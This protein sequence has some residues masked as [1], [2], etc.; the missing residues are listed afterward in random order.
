MNTRA[1]APLRESTEANER[2]SMNE[3]NIELLSEKIKKEK[4]MDFLNHRFNEKL[5]AMKNNKHKN[6]NNANNIIDNFHDFEFENFKNEFKR[7]NIHYGFSPSKEKVLDEN[8]NT[9]GNLNYSKIIKENRKDQI[10]ISDEQLCEFK[11]KFLGKSEF[12]DK[13]NVKMF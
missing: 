2:N 13:E 12:I 5:F 6:S 7:N 11:D 9:L 3:A 4:Q 8:L 10:L 1:K